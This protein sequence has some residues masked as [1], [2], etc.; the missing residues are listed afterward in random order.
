MPLQ[1]VCVVRA[2]SDIGV[3]RRNAV[4]LA[5]NAGF[6]ETEAGRVAL[7]ATELAT[8]LVRH[9]N[10]GELLLQTVQ[11][12]DTREV[13]LL[14]IDRG[15]GMNIGNTLR[16]GFSSGGTAGQGLGAIQ[17]LSEEFDVYSHPGL[18]CVVLARVSDRIDF[19]HPPVRSPWRWGTVTVAAPGE[20][21]IGD[22]WRI[23]TSGDDMSVLVA[24]GLGH[25]PLAHAASEK[26]AEVFEGSAFGSLSAFFTRAHSELRSTRGAAVAVATCPMASNAM[27]FAGVGN[28]AGFIVNR[29]GKSKGLMSHNGTVG[30]EMRSANS[31]AYEWMAGDRLVMHSDGL[32]SR[33]SFREYPE[34]LEH[35]PAILAALLYRDHLRGRDDAT[36]LVLERPQ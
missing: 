36:V 14:S 1:I 5:I 26:A 19:T 24:D 18:G 8:N 7:V 12:G 28:I 16:D 31:L 6:G 25:G 22:T 2:Q 21:V 20:I 3:A 29:A 23:K 34:V 33:W 9:A 17:R 30:A 13:E 15:P 10:G 35:H 27:D 4:A 11:N 32:T